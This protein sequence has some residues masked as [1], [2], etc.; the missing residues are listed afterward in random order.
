M[1]ARE[2]KEKFGL[3]YCYA[4][5][6]RDIKEKKQKHFWDNAEKYLKNLSK[7]HRFKKGHSSYRRISATEREKF[8]IQIKK[9]NRRKKCFIACPVCKIKY[10][11]LESHLYNAHGLLKVKK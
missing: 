3:P 6:D 2:Y 9:V 1:I 11:H 4:L 7:K 8:I 10:K 5:I